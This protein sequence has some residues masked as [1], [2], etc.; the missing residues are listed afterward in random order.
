MSRS[1]RDA[2]S[3]LRGQNV[4]PA[5]EGW[6]EDPDGPFNFLF[7]YMNRNWEEEIDVPIGPDNTIEPGARIGTTDALA[8]S[9]QPVRFQ[10]AGPE[11][12]RREGELVWT[13]TTKGKTEKAYATLRTD[14]KVDAIVRAS[15]TGALGAGTSE[16]VIRANQAPTIKMDGEKQARSV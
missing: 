6:E 9:P 3:Y 2:Q 12:L 11:G 14:S 1:G 4:S 10:G 7:G 8:P 15:E 5:F 16:P 13:L